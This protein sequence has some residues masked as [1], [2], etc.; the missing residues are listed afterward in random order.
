MSFA[1]ARSPRVFV[2]HSSAEQLALP[3]VPGDSCVREDLKRTYILTAAPASSIANW[4]LLSVYSTD[5]AIRK[6]I[7]DWEPDGEGMWMLR[8]LHGLQ[9]KLLSVTV[10]DADTEKEVQYGIQIITVDEVQLTTTMVPD[11]RASVIVA[12]EAIIL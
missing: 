11:G 7:T 4:S 1:V 5:Y 9:S 2:V 10:F 8:L 6:E 3:G 12:I